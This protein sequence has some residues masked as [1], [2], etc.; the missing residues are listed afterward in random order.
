ML[1]VVFICSADVG[2]AFV[3]VDEF[4]DVDLTVGKIN[5]NRILS[6]S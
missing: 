5:S 6:Y 4:H 2:C 3:G 1:V